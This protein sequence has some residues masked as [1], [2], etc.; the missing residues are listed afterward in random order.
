MIDFD[1][2]YAP[3]LIDLARQTEHGEELLA[4]AKAARRV[5][6]HLDFADRMWVMDALA[7]KA[8]QLK[9]LENGVLASILSAVDHS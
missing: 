5:W 2:D 9:D 7:E 3:A 6:P 4:V 1:P 8:V